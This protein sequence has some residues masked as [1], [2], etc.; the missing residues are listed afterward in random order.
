VVNKTGSRLL[1]GLAAVLLSACASHALRADPS[2]QVDR[3]FAQ[4]AEGVRPGAAVM[5]IREAEPEGLS[6]RVSDIY[7]DAD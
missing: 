5:V 6:D 3:L 7:L 2:S 4:F 1:I